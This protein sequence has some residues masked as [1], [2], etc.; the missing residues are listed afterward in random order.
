MNSKYSFLTGIYQ[1]QPAIVA[2]SGWSLRELPAA[3]LQRYPVFAVNA[4]Y[5][6][7]EENKLKKPKYLITADDNFSLIYKKAPQLFGEKFICVRHP[8]IL[9]SFHWEEVENYRLE[10][11][12]GKI[13]ADGTSSHAALHI[14]LIAECNPIYLCGVDLSLG[15]DKQV[16]C[17]E[18]PLCQSKEVYEHG[19]NLMHRG[20][21][22]LSEL[23]GRGRIF[24]C[25]PD[26]KL[27]CFPKI[28]PQ[29]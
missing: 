1:G 2:A 7:F 25:S 27:N 17:T 10:S 28:K 23:A 4:A 16:Y 11:T 29:N 9:D 8:F 3:F 15:P 26:G 14:A 20:F 22:F 12:A 13:I 6:Y 21:E 19:W 18:E 24:D 5:R